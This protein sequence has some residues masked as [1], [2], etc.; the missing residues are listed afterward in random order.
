MARLRRLRRD[1]I[2]STSGERAG[3]GLA[4]GG[5]SPGVLFIDG[6]EYTSVATVGAAAMSGVPTSALS[7]ATAAVRTIWLSAQQL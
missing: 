1:Q 6:S 2:R 5:L 7:A 3:E 4:V